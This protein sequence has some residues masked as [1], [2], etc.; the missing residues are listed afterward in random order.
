MRRLFLNRGMTLIEVVV[1]L[2]LISVSVVAIIPM[3][4]FGTKTEQ[5]VEARTT[6]I[7]LAQEKMEAL[8]AVTFASLASETSA[9]V[10][11]FSGFSRGVQVTSTAS[12]LK[13]IVVT[14]TWTSKFANSAQSYQLATL[15]A[16]Y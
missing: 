3:F 15:R 6:A 10:S 9:A 16:N 8:Q 12:N 5:Q 4:T 13:K 14:V 7:S 2:F 11:G 1:T